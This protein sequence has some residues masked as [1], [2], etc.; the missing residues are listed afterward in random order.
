MTVNPGVEGAEVV[1][2]V[3]PYD[4]TGLRADSWHWGSTTPSGDSYDVFDVDVSGGDDTYTLPAAT[5]DNLGRVAWVSKSDSSTNTLTITDTGTVLQ[6]QYQTAQFV[7]DGSVWLLLNPHVS[8][9]Q[10][11]PI[12]WYDIRD[13]GAVPGVAG[14]ART[15]AAFNAIFAEISATYTPPSTITGGLSAV[16]YV[17]F[18]DVADGF[19][20]VG[21]LNPYMG[22]GG[23]ALRM[24]GDA[25]RGYTGGGAGSTIR[26][27]G[28]PRGTMFDFVAI[29]ASSFENLAFDGGGQALVVVKLRQFY[30]VANTFQVA[31]NGVSFTNC[32]FS[33]PHNS[34]DSVLVQA[35]Q[36]DDPPNTFQ[37]ADYWFFRCLFEGN[38]FGPGLT[39]QGWGF[40]T[41]VAGNTKNFSFDTCTFLA[42]YRGIETY[43]G[44]LVLK[45]IEAGN[46]GYDRADAAVIY[47][48]GNTL[49]VQGVGLENGNTGYA[50][51]LI[52]AGQGIK[53]FLTG[54]YVAATPPTD[55]YIL[56]LGGGANVTACDLGGNSR[57]PSSYIAWA[58]NSA[59][60]VGQERKNDSPAKV[61][62][63]TVSGTTAG[64]GGPTGTG[65]GIVDGSAH[66][67]YVTSN[68]TGNVLK[69]QVGTDV[70]GWGGVNIISCS[71]PCTT[72]P[73]DGVPLYDGSNNPIFG[74]LGSAGTDFAKGRQHKTFA[75][76][77]STGI[78]GANITTQLLDFTGAEYTS[79]LDQFLNDYIPASCTV[80][81]NGDGH[82]ALIVPAAAVAAGSSGATSLVRIWEMA[83]V[84]HRVKLTDIIMDVTTLFSGPG[85]SG[86]SASI[87]GG[88]AYAVNGMLQSQPIDTVATYGLDPTERGPEWQGD[89][90]IPWDTVVAPVYLTIT[91]SGGTLTNVNAGSMTLYFES[92]RLGPS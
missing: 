84:P 39:R 46:I 48:G 16:V 45:Q 14:Q 27:N 29:N 57:S 76:G 53:T 42:L 63:C 77:C 6:Y 87:G 21:D 36:D 20:Y 50:A 2:R 80:I 54:A 11:R 10:P 60:L 38:D 74:T 4:A 12:G 51:R 31:S 15:T 17:P 61:Y 1:I 13:Y 72:T 81:R 3:A 78:Y 68:L 34:Y 86:I 55:D 79:L 73:V 56:R 24:V 43:S 70:P 90:W 37:A 28:T 92:A 85:V 69:I 5:P 67:D 65:M 25:P 59:V 22:N 89:R 40:K 49:T 9:L 88:G 58:P 62:V 41:A 75:Q 71:F 33:N 66:W 82:Y 64:S 26:F 32:V 47:F 7:S 35:G 83:D 19:W 23:D 30:N 18:V 52:T 8:S 44:Y 91:A